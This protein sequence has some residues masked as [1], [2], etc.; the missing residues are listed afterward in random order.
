MKLG[1]ALKEPLTLERWSDEA[2]FRACLKLAD[3]IGRTIIKKK[4]LLP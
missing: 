2:V 1:N 3:A 4:A